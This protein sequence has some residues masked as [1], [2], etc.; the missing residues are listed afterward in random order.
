MII[1]KSLG[2]LR[3]L[4][5]M[6]D[7]R[8]QKYKK[9]RIAGMNRYNAARAAGYSESYADKCA[10]KLEAQIETDLRNAFERRGW[11]DKAIVEYAMEALQA[12]RLQACDVI[13]R[14]EDGKLVP[15]ENSNDFIEIPDWNARHK[16][17]ATIMEL[18]SRIKTKVEHSGKIDGPE[19]RIIIVYPADYKAKGDRI[20]AASKDISG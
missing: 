10:K 8:L 14:K 1:H 13:V 15:N 17:F 5:F 9:N 2:I 7:I 20:G 12:M 16:F 4:P 18:T 3:L 6:K 11:T 19:Q